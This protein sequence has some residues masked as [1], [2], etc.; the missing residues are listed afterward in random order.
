MPRPIIFFGSSLNPP[1]KAHLALVQYMIEQ[2]KNQD[3]KPIIVLAP[4]YKHMFSKPDLVDF[5][6]R[7]K[8][9]EAQFKTEIANGDVIVSDIE[10]VVYRDMQQKMAAPGQD[11]NTVKAS[12]GTVDVLQYMKD[13]PGVIPNGDVNHISLMLGG[14]TYN[15]FVGGKWKDAERII[16]LCDTIHVFDRDGLMPADPQTVVIHAREA[17]DDVRREKLA[18]I[19]TTLLVS[20]SFRFGGKFKLHRDAIIDP[21]IQ[22]I[23]STN[24]RNDIAHAIKGLV[25]DVLKLMRDEYHHLFKSTREERE[26]MSTSTASPVI[27]SDQ[28]G[29]VPNQ[30][31]KNN[32]RTGNVAGHEERQDDAKKTRLE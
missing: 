26:K 30:S 6:P 1:T 27:T 15:D 31:G 20:E 5:G 24:I 13:H 29:T 10:E 11:P 32:T 7:V 3:P 8:L 9:T 4:V 22:R 19:E 25:D 2:A 17:A 28:T 14:D 21:D 18:K 12:C 23:S 16:D